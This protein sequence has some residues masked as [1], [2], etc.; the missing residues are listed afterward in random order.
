[1]AQDWRDEVVLAVPPPSLILKTLLKFQES[2]VRGIVV[3]PECSS[4]L[5]VAAWKSEKLLV[6]RVHQWKFPGKGILRA[7]I[8]TRY[9]HEYNGKIVVD[10]LDFN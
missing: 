1:M 10:L 9:N 5:V 8:K 6:G 4:G 7:N 2:K 3:Y